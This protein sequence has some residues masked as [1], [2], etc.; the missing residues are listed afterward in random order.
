MCLQ[1]FS[2]LFTIFHEKDT[3][4]VYLLLTNDTPSST[5]FRTLHPF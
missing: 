3:P 2:Y 5:L 4:F 1:L